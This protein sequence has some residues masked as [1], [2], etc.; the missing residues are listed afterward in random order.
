MIRRDRPGGRP[1]LRNR[2]SGTRGGAAGPGLA[3]GLRLERRRVSGPVANSIPCA[4]EERLY[5]QLGCRWVAPELREDPGEVERAA[6]GDLPALVEMAD[7]RGSAPQSHHAIPMDR[8]ASRRWAVPERTGVGVSGDRRSLSGRALCKRPVGGQARGSV[9]RIDAFNASSPKLRI[10]KGLEADI[11]PDG[12][13]T[14]PTVVP[15]S[16]SM[17]WRRFIHRF[18][19][20]GRPDRHG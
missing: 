4:D 1:G 18:G 20:R 5:D 15:A 6:A 10:I 7:I 9:A 12:S 14:S 16:S 3:A 11:L 17:W 19:F 2:R 13:S 8:R